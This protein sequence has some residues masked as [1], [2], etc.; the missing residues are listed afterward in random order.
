M[1]HLCYLFF[2]LIFIFKKFTSS[3]AY[4]L[5]YKLLFLDENLDEKCE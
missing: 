1:S 2:V 4:F 3:F 5:E